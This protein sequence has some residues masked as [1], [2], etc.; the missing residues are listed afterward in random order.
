MQR[1]LRGWRR[2]LRA[3]PGGHAAHGGMPRTTDAELKALERTSP[4]VSS[5]SSSTC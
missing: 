3:D 5:A 4:A 1:R 2:P